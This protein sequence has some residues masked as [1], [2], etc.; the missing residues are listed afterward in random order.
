MEQELKPC[1][2]CGGNNL[3]FSE[4]F[5]ETE[6]VHCHSCNAEGPFWG[7]NDSQ[8]K[9]EATDKWNTRVTP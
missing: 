4:I 8:S 2:F 6:V 7:G 9:Q 5:D 3:G 1:P